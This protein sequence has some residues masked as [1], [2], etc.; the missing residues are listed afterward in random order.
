MQSAMVEVL[1][2]QRDLSSWQNRRRPLLRVLG[3][4]AGAAGLRAG[5]GRGH[6]AAGCH[7]AALLRHGWRRHSDCGSWAGG[8]TTTA[9]AGRGIRDHSTEAGW[10]RKSHG[11]AVRGAALA[12][13]AL[14]CFHTHRFAHMGTCLHCFALLCIVLTDSVDFTDFTDLTAMTALTA[15]TDV[16]VLIVFLTRL[17]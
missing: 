10:L 11:V 16:T 6:R 14:I 2:L 9:G 8:G 1:R 15:L 7:L 4:V 17:K 13:L 3:R 12:W 5:H